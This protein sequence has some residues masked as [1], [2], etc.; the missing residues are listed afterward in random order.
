VESQKGYIGHFDHLET[1]TRDVTH[2]MAL[3]TEAC[4][5]NL[6]TTNLDEVQTAVIG[7]ESSDLLAVLDELNSDTLSDGRIGLQ[8][9]CVYL[10]FF[11]DNS[12]GMGSSSKGVGLQGSAQVSLLV[13][14]IMPLLFATVVTQL[15]GCTQTTTLACRK[16]SKNC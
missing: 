2:S 15:P 1:N 4:H 14:L 10:H 9:K 12:L 7:N 13:L 11:E 3:A 6:P 5:Q 16:S 8:K